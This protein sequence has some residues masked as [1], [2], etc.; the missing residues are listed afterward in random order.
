MVSIICSDFFMKGT[1]FS[2]LAKGFLE[3]ASSYSKICLI[4]GNCGVVLPPRSLT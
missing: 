2:S 1:C 3:G 4:G